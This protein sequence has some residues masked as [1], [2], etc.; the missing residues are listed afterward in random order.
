MESL[1]PE[2]WNP[3]AMDDKDVAP[4][5]TTSSTE[6]STATSL[7]ES[8]GQRRPR[9]V[10]T[11]P[12]PKAS[13]TP[14]SGQWANDLD[15]RTGDEGD[16]AMT[17]TDESARLASQDV[18]TA[19]QRTPQVSEVLVRLFRAGPLVMEVSLR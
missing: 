19:S 13:G 14:G 7:G 6:K 3:F 16:F 2:E 15:G 10:T 9:H 17:D 5:T 12:P 8:K 1:E 18:S 4:T 11:V